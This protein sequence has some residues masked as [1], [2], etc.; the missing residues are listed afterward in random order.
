MTL[1]SSVPVQ[2]GMY[3]SMIISSGLNSCMAES[4][5]MGSVMA[6]AAIP[7]FVNVLLIK[8]A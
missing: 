3:I 1:A 8:A 5:C 6:V 2:P 4:V 7:A